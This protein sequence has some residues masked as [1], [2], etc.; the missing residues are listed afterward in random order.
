[1]RLLVDTNVFL[2]FLLKRENYAH[3]DKFFYYANLYK[4]QI[5]I[6][7]MSMRDIGYVVRKSIHNNEMTRKLQIAA[8][9]MVSKVISIS[10]DSAIES[11]YSCFDDYED[12]IQYY[13]A[14]ESMCDAIVTYNKKDF[15]ESKLPIFTPEEIYIIWSDKLNYN[16]KH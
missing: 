10:S 4:N 1:M 3:V 15:K 13:A 14:E 7:S 2:E 9:S 12:S 11:L 8:Y 16:I 6:T 5:F